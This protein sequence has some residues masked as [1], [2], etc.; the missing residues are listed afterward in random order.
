MQIWGAR[1]PLPLPP[2]PALRIGRIASSALILGA[3]GTVLSA[4]CQSPHLGSRVA[5]QLCDLEGGPIV[6]CA[7]PGL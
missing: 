3:H 7:G 6:I 5:G 1:R 2:L 4:G